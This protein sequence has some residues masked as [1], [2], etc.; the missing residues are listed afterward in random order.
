MNAGEIIQ[1]ATPGEMYRDPKTQFVA[2]FLGNPPIAFLKGASNGAAVNVANSDIIVPLP[3]RIRADAGRSLT[4]GIRPE[5]FGPQGSVAIPGTVA[6]VETQ[7]RENL[8]DVKL[9]NGSVLR[10]I[11]PVRDDVKVGDAVNWGAV[12]DKIMVFAEDGLR[13]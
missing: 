7:G 10:S 6:F 3:S 1:I 4:L 2:G 13:L 11:Q 9:G 5:D 12:D 8:Y